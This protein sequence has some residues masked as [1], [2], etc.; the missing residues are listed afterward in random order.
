[1]SLGH[2][3]RDVGRVLSE[4]DPLGGCAFLGQPGA[5]DC[6]T[7]RS[8]FS[9]PASLSRSASRNFAQYHQEALALLWRPQQVEALGT[10]VLTGPGLLR[11]P[12][13]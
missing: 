9:K 4:C 6:T 12:L 8:L 11:A 5:R 3:G 10:A 13:C 1:M 2:A 7:F